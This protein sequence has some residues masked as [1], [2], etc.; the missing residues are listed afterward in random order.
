MHY[1]GTNTSLAGLSVRPADSAPIK[2]LIFLLLLLTFAAGIPATVHAKGGDTLWTRADAVAG[3]QEAK[4]MTVDSAGDT[5]VVGYTGSNA[6]DYYVAKF[7]ADGTGT[8]WTPVTF[9]GTGEDVAT[10][11]TVDSVDNIIVT[12]YTWNGSDKDIHTIKYCGSADPAT[13]CPGKSPGEMLWQHTLTN[14]SGN[15][16]AAAVAVDGDDNIYV[17]GAYFNAGQMDDF[18]VIK[19]PAAGAVPTWTE[20]F[21]DDL[22]NPNKINKILAMAVNGT[23]IAVTGY[24]GRGTTF[25]MLT[26][27]Y[28]LDMSFIRGWRHSDSG[29]CMG[30]AVRMDAA[31]NV[32]VTGSSTNAVNNKDIYTVKYDPASDTALWEKTYN[33]NSTDEPLGLW[34]DSAGDAYVSGVTNTLAGNDDFFTARYDGANGDL[35][36]KAIFD[37]GNDATDI[38]SGIVVDDAADGGVFVTGY[39]TV[40]GNDDFMTLKYR[41]DNGVLLWEKAWNGSDSKNDRPIGIALEP[42]GGPVPRSVYVAGWSDSTAT[43][44]DYQLVK[45]DH[46]PLNAPTSLTAAVVFDDA[47]KITLTW[48]DNSINE[49]KF[50]IERKQGESGTWGAITPDKTSLAPPNDTTV[51]PTVPATTYTNDSL[52]TNNFY[53]YRIRAWNS[54]NTY[55]DYSNEARALTKVVSIA[56]PAWSYT[57]NGADNRDDVATAITTDTD[58]HPVVSGYSDLTEEGVEGMYSN[59]YMT[60]KLD[61]ID[62]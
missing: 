61:R 59:D 38:P 24:S 60:Y 30:K 31:G 43:G 11:V 62:K 49:E 25:D 39:S 52:T 20:I 37:A 12:G 5:I 10:A 46:G 28:G 6:N 16:S 23:G 58:N 47:S 14:T 26:R 19:Y 41:K 53:Y 29:D 45:Y 22:A 3:K 13:D 27:K 55:S 35:K 56:V 33:G 57:Y 2:L 54:A 21:G 44:Y 18:V 42:A 48:Y 9:G 8:A 40:S 17:A 4:A 15:D 1:R 50:V 36:W 7:K 32:I 34:V 51:I